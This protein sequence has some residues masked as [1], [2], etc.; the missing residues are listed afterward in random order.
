MNVRNCKKCGRLFN[1]IAGMPL[2]QSCREAMEE[3]FQEVKKYVQQHR[4]AGVREVSEECEVEEKQIREW[5]REERLEFSEGT[6]AGIACES[7]GVAITTG[8][9]CKQ[10][11]AALASTFSQAG[12]R[13]QQQQLNNNTRRDPNGGMRYINN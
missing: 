11:K 2:C 6:V 3:K 8:R 4:N 7:C 1:Y 10:C 12:R 9:F 5:V 13:P